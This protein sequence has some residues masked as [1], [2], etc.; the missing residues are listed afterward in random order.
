VPSKKLRTW[1]VTLIRNR[2]LLVGFVE[3]RDERAAEL[4]AAIAFMLSEW[5]RKRLL[6]RERH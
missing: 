6:V 4:A 1:A 2:G 5:Q 3:A